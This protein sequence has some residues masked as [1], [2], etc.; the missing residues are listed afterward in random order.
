VAIRPEWTTFRKRLGY[1]VGV[2][3]RELEKAGLAVREVVANAIIHGNRLDD[4]KKVVLTFLRTPNQ[5]KVAVW[6]QGKDSTWIACPIPS[7]RKCCS[8]ST[9]AESICRGRSWMSF[10][11]RPD[12]R[13]AP[14]SPWSNTFAKARLAGNSPRVPFG[15]L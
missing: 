6:D 2:L 11:C 12:P 9:G 4:Q 14:Q 5:L 8:T 1:Q 3:G 10:M 15:R 7:R 13:V